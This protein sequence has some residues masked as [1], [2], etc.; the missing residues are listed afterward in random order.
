MYRYIFDIGGVLVKYEHEKAVKFLAEAG[1]YDPE[2]VGTLFSREL[3]YSVESGR[4]SSQSFYEE[5][6][7][8]V[9]PGITYDAWL[10][11]FEEYFEV[12]PEG[13]E[14]MLDVKK[15]GKRVYLLSNLAEYHK[16]AIERK[17]PGFFEHTDYNFLSYEMGYCKPEPEIYRTV[18]RTI[19]ERPENLVFFDDLPQ[20]IEGARKEGI[21]GVLF[22]NNRITEIR[23]YIMEL[24]AV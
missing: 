19:S 8:R 21:K 4:I 16:V 1:D 23:K 24:E 6:I 18:C 17:I 12:N 20:N 2:A 15:M 9:M 5:H 22:S 7:K 13:F 3:V 14:L 11:R 10:K